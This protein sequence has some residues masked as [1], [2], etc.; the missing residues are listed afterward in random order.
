M[1]D[2]VVQRAHRLDLS[3][4]NFAGLARL[5]FEVGDDQKSEVAADGGEAGPNDTLS[6][7]SRR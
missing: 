4:M 7:A 1:A 6:A 3:G 5:S 2:D